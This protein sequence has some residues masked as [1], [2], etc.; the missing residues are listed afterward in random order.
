[1]WGTT[2]EQGLPEL[3]NSPGCGQLYLLIRMCAKVK[4]RY[5]V[6]AK[7][8]SFPSQAGFSP[9]LP[10]AATEFCS[11]K[12]KCFWQKNAACDFPAAKA[13]LGNAFHP[14]AYKERKWNVP[15]TENQQLLTTFDPQGLHT[16]A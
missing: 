7:V 2:R 16:W 10:V 3:H 5:K 13:E 12:G 15:V 11:Q 9:L 8:N 6:C 4:G 14:L 1:M